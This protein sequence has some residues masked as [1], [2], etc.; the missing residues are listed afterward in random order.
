MSDINQ[1]EQQAMQFQAKAKD[2]EALKCY[3]QILKLDPNNRRIRKTIGDIYI[4]LGDLRNAERRYLE[5][6]ESMR[7]D[8]LYRM[9]IPLYKELCKMRAK[10][11]DMFVELGECYIRT[12][13]SNDAITCYEKAVAM[14]RRQKPEYAQEIQKKLCSLRPSDTSERIKLAEILEHANWV[15]KACDE[16]GTLAET[17]RKI[18]KYDDQAIFLERAISIRDHWELRRDAARARLIVGDSR[19]ALQHLK[20]IYKTHSGNYEVCMLLAEG[21]QRIK[22]IGQASKVWVQAAEICQEEVEVAR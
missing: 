11:P 19:Q 4:K 12:N 15:E 17:S 20:S 9:A 16:W 14:T 5:V 7:K 10:D 21:L 18:G 13:A 1:L 8:G 6:V 22:K 3:L 2:E